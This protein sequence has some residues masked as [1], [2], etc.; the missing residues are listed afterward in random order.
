MKQVE[1]DFP[2][3]M[4]VLDDVYTDEQRGYMWT[5]LEYIYNTGLLLPPEETKP[6][7]NDDGSIKKQNKSVFLTTIYPPEYYTQSSLIMIPRTVLLQ[8]SVVGMMEKMHPMHGI[9]R[10]VNKVGPLVSYYEN[11]DHY[12]SHY[13]EAA[14]TSLSYLFKEPQAFTGG[15]VVIDINGYSVTIPIKNN[16]VIIFPSCYPHAVTNVHMKEEDKGKM[17]GRFCITQFFF[18]YANE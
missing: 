6:A 12:D 7:R 8:P 9:L 16:R 13:D 1:I 3:D 17:M 10:N 15:D 2:Y 5:E 18:I 4:L 11:S 14:Y